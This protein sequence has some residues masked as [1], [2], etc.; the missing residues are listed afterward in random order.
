MN[1]GLGRN[2]SWYIRLFYQSFTEPHCQC[3][4]TAEQSWMIVTWNLDIGPSI[5]VYPIFAYLAIYE[6]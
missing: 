6:C 3:D 1:M 2:Q 4:W 5:I